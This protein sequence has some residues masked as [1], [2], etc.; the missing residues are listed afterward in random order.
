[1]KTPRRTIALRLNQAVVARI[2]EVRQPLRMSRSGWLRKA[3]ERNLQF[4]TEHEL[5]VV[6][7]Q[8]IQA[9]LLPESI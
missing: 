8:D 1:M 6:A 9:V 4:T 3:V 7:R 2:D 5:P